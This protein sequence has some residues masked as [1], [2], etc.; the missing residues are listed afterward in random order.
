MVGAFPFVITMFAMIALL[1]MFPELAL[2]FSK[3]F[4]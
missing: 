1:I 3:L 2:W 4:Y